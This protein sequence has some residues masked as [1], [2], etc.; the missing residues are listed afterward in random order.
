MI[1]GEGTGEKLSPVLN[2]PCDPPHDRGSDGE[3][4]LS[5]YSSCDGESEFERYCSA[6]SAMGTPS[7]C[8]S[9]FQDSDFG[10]L[11]SF[12]L[13]DDVCSFKNFGPKRVLSGFRESESPSGSKRGNEFSSVEKINGLL[14]L[15]GSAEGFAASDVDLMRK[16][17]LDGNWGNEGVNE[18]SNVGN[19][20]GDTR[21]LDDFRGIEG[22]T[23]CHRDVEEGNDEGEGLEYEGEDR[24]S[25]DEDEALSRYEHSEGEDS[26]F[27]CYSDDERKINSYSQKNVQFQAEGPRKNEY[28]FVMNSSVA[29]G[30]DDWDDFVQESGDRNLASMVWHEFQGGKQ[31]S[32]EREI[33][34]IKFPPVIFAEQ[35]NETRSIPV[36]HNQVQ[37]AT[38]LADTN[39]N[40]F[41]TDLTTHMKLDAGQP[42]DD[43]EG[44]LSSNLGSGVDGVSEYLESLSILNI[45]ERNQDPLTKES[46]VNEGSEI[47]GAE[48]EMKHQDTST[49]DVTGIHDGIVSRNMDLEKTNLE[50][51]PP[52]ESGS[53]QHCLISREYEE[54]R[55][56]EFLEDNNPVSSSSL[57]DDC[58]SGMKRNSAFSFNRF[59]DHFAPVRTKDL[60]L[61]DFYDEFVN[62][63]EE[64]LLDSGESPRSRFTQGTRVYQSQLPRPLRD[65]GSAAST[66][67]T[68]DAYHL[69]HQPLRIDGI[70]VVGARQ[71]K[72]DVS[73]TERLVGVKE[74]TVYRIRVWSGE[75]HWEVERRYRDFNAL[76]RRLKKQFADQGWRIPSPWSSV[77]GESRK[78]FGN[79]SPGVVADRS[80][81]IQECLRSILQP[82]FPSS[83]L[84][85]LISFLSP[86]EFVP[87]SPASDTRA[88]HSPLPNRG[89]HLENVSTLGKTISLVVQIRPYKSMKQILDAQHYTCAGCH[90]NF[91]DG[92][93]RVQ[94]FVHALG[95]G[96]P[97]LCEYSGQLFCSSCHNNDAAV[98][99]ARVLHFWDFTQYPV[100]QL[101]KSYLDSIYD[102]PMLCVSAVNPFLF[103]KVPALQH[104]ANTRKRVIAMLPY[105][106]CPFRG[107]IYK[108]LRS[109]RYLLESNDFFSL[110]DLIDLSKGVFSALPV[111]VETVFRKIQEHITEQ[112]LVC[113][114]AGI[115]CS[116][117]LACNDPS[118]LI[119]PFQEG[120]I[121]KCKFCESVF[122]KNCFRKIPT[123]P[124]GACLN[125]QEVKQSTAER[126][127][128]M[129]SE[130]NINSDLLRSKA[131]SSSGLL[132]GLFSKLVPQKSHGLTLQR[133]EGVDNV[134]LMGSL[135]NTSL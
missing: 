82:K 10:S 26:M 24:K 120:D 56:I 50:L 25:L 133:P 19:S 53:N 2:S 125:S 88:P 100:S 79:S 66:S 35:K 58:M 106:R 18:N 60:E 44:V 4:V 38:E 67:G 16:L 36:V 13:G 46:P 115:P 135:P 49:G 124:C 110:K 43:V 40:N 92:R 11:K 3:D 113:Y 64:I 42:V 17:D 112:C 90:K 97:R 39:T 41:S 89:S 22:G 55:K 131:E 28:Q 73:L 129:V 117:R 75:D 70:E 7:L 93:T 72:G 48:L 123:C 95:W 122:H 134:I 1:N 103:P 34:S 127:H 105:V 5:Q 61:N 102:Q 71:E 104:V 83:F 128:G 69:F 29:F 62:D 85:A 77:E 30:S 74:Y 87:G 31:P 63:M 108:G 57:A 68:D 91:D 37:G 118:S 8:G 23:E 80:I 121:E 27:G 119:F 14:N 15:G 81:L 116:A 59:E 101:A 99:P 107:S 12:K 65:G 45:F 126:I 86:S 20:E 52:L 9:S 21:V 96:K 51:N 130:A 84:S 54:V 78:I 33:D 98:L 6:N 76:Y 132:A 109:R 32:I 111:M 47:G 114:D 94:E